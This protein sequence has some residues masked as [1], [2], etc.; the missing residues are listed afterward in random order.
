M[1]LPDCKEDRVDSIIQVTQTFRSPTDL[2][3]FRNWL[4]DQ[5]PSKKEKSESQLGPTKSDKWIGFGDRFH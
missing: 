2:Q 4:L 1:V 3:D 5:G